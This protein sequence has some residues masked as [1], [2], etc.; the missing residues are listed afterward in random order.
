[1]SKTSPNSPGSSV[2]LRRAERLQIRWRD[3]VLDEMIPSDAPVRAIWQ[4]VQSL[5]LSPLLEKVR[6]VE[7][8]VGRDATDPAIL[9]TLWMYAIIEGISSARKLAKLTTRDWT[10]IWI[11]G[12]VSV[13]Y[14]MLSDFRTQHGEFLEQLLV[15][16]VAALMHQEVVTLK[17]VAQDG[18]RVRANAGSSSFRRQKTLEACREAAAKQLQELNEENEENESESKSQD[19][20]KRRQAAKKRAA[21]ER[22][23]RVAAALEN[24]KELQQQK[25][26]RK[27]GSGENARSSTTDPDA[28][29]MKMADGG[30][31]PAL[32]VQ[33]VTDADSRIIV[34]VDV[35]NNGS[36]A[37]QMSPMHGKLQEQFGC[38]PED[39]LVDGGFTTIDEVTKLEQGNSRV[40][41]PIPRARETL[42]KGKD[43]HARGKKDT[44]EMARFRER[45]ATDEA[46]SLLKLR[47]SVAEFPNATCRNNGLSQFPVRGLRK[48][49]VIALW[50]ALVHNFMR[51]RH[52]R[53]A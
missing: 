27:K 52:L 43:P 15:D 9:M 19:N 35:S 6:A 7:G 49:K 31:R 2:R 23:A 25:E 12:D 42:R 28:R 10:Y 33:F 50:H 14:H 46:K 24:L 47:P 17:T 16:S 51:M 18:M 20:D 5:D 37:S 11:C 36:D 32:N 53:L 40:I 13:N 8:N 39:Y 30:H 4:Y 48:A 45:M 29:V 21:T 34:G 3:V 41:G 44:D 22:G 1:M 26:K 38:V